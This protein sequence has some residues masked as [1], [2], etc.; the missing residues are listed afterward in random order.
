MD[1][2]R[3]GAE[4][5]VARLSAL[6]R[7]V[8]ADTLRRD[9][10]DVNGQPRPGSPYAAEV[11]AAGGDVLGPG[12][13]SGLALLWILDAAPDY[14]DALDKRAVGNHCSA[15]RASAARSSHRRARRQ[16]G[17]CFRSLSS[18]S[19]SPGIACLP[20]RRPHRAVAA[21]PKGGDRLRVVAHRVRVVP[22]DVRSTTR[23]L[24]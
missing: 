21:S 6:M 8:P 17:P 19:G 4:D 20:C 24:C 11:I 13:S 1:L 2:R 22:W 23:L 18:P 9:A 10:N 14:M 12:L 5:A 3:F 15:P 7:I 16:G